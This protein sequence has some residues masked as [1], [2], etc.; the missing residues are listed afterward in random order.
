M[1]FKEYY[2]ERINEKIY[3]GKSNNGLKVYYIPK[4]GY[5]KKHAI[6]STN[7]GSIDNEFV[8]IGEEKSLLVP[9]GIAHFLEHK[10]FEE[11]DQDIF[12]VF[13]KRGASVNAFT[14]FS[15]T[16]Y[17]FH[18]TDYFYENLE[19][20]I[21]FVQNPYLTD[22][23]VEKEKGII[24]QEIKMYEDNPGWRVYFNLLNAMYSKHPVKIDIAGTVESIKTIDKD[25]LYRA[26]NTF[27]HP[28][29][30]MLFIVGDLSFEKIMDVVNK[31][32][33]KYKNFDK[34]ERILALEP[35]SIKNKKVEEEMP[36]SAP[37]IFTGFKD[38]DFGYKGAK[39]I[40]KDI[41]TNIAL[42]MVLGSSSK[43][44]NE[45]YNEG[46][47]DSGFGGYYSSKESYGYSIISG[48][49]QDPELVHEKIV[50]LIRRP[51][52]D[53]LKEED[54]IRIKK[55]ETGDFLLGL[56]SLGFIANSFTDLYFDDFLIIDYLDLMETI[57]YGEIVDRFKTHFTEENLALSILRP[58]AL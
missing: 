23:N 48:E 17:L 37:I 27:Y 11:P 30:M 7:Y 28:S 19:T 15:Q 56:N 10:L 1:E 5:T 25:L 8:P 6:F 3:H 22:E 18:S 58:K 43:F 26:Y 51:A 31:S 4:K 45:L 46:L 21:K 57:E 16:S 33:K 40:K 12:E 50:K 2:N 49:T 36:T 20:L 47:I 13:S 35:T 32:E 9:E 52:E 55:N 54:F 29:N 44:Y 34:I 38:N 24:A 53:I 39:K 42:D 14:N 41:I